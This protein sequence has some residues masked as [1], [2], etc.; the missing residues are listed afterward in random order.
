MAMSLSADDEDYESDAE[1]QVS[2]T[3]TGPKFG[4]QAAT[5]QDLQTHNSQIYLTDLTQDLQTQCRHRTGQNREGYGCE[6]CVDVCC[7]VSVLFFF[8][9]LLW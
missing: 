2:N 4:Q 7:C 5:Q 9:A 1:Q 3:D 8:M 6:I